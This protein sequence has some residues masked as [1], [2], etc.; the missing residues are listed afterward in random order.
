ML[1][2]LKVYTQSGSYVLTVNGGH[3]TVRRENQK[4]YEATKVENGSPQ[5]QSIYE[6]LY[7]LEWLI[8]SA[9]NLK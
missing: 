2:E 8:E 1:G 4:P 5:W 7:K 9:V 3:C 6:Q